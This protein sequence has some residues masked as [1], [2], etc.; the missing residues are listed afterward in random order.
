[1]KKFI[2]ETVSLLIELVEIQK[3]VHKPN[4]KIPN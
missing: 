1:M 4:K 3:E 2:G